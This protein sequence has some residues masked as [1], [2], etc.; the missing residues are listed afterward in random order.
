MATIV[1]Q[2]A[3][4]F[5]GGFLGPVGTAIGSAAG[6]MA[7][8][9]LDRALIESTQHH[10]GARLSGAR[11]FTAEDGAALPRVYGTA[12]IGG[13][14]IWATRFEESRLTERQGFKGGPRV[15]EYSYFANAA[16]A[17]CEGRIAGIRRIWADGRE[18]D[19]EQVEIRVYDGSEGQAA[20][21]LVEARQGEGNTPAY[22][23]TAYVVF[24]RFPIGDYGN[25]IPQFQFEVL[26]PVGS[27]A[28]DIRAVALI[29]GSTEFGLS[30][31][32]VTRSVQAGETEAL[33]RHVL[34]A[35]TDLVASLDE[36]QALCPGLEHVALVATWFGS[37]LRAGECM[38][39]PAVIDNAATGFSDEWKVSGMGRGF[40]P[41]VSTFNGSAAYGGSPSDRTVMDAIAEIKR[42]G[43]KVTL[44]PFV[45]MDIP[46]GNALPD[47]YGG[48]AQ[49][50]YPWRGRIS[51]DPAPLRPGSADKTADARAQV[52]QFCGS[53]VAAD[54]AAHADTIAFNGPLDDWGYRRF[55]LHFA[56]LAAA[57]GG[58]DGFLVGSELRGLTTLRDENNGFPFVEQLCDLA[59]EARA[60]LGPATKITYG[61]DWSEYFGHHPA[62]GSGDVF[63]HLDA[64]WAH[65]AVDAVG[66]D[67]YMPLADWRDAD[68]VEGNPDGFS[69]PYDLDGLKRAMAGGEG[70]DWYYP[71]EAARANR[72]RAPITDGAYGK[73]WVYR[74]KD[75]ESWWSNLHYNRVGGQEAAEPTDW[76]SQ[77]KP[78]WMTEVG[79][80]A[81]DKGPN[82]PNVFPD[83]KS[84]ESAIPYFSNGGRSD[85]ASQRFLAAHFSYWDPAAPGF[86]ASNN[87]LSPVYGGR[88]VDASRIYVWAWDAR[89]FPAFP[90]GQD[91]WKDSENWR[92]G[93]WLNGRLSSLSCGDLID[94]IL[95][96]H[97][98]PQ[99]DTATADGMMHGYVVAD[100]SS[101]RAA[102]E[103][104]IDLYGLSVCEV[105]GKLIF[106]REGAQLPNAVPVT[107]LVVEDRNAVVETV[108]VP[109][110]DLPTEAILGFR[111]PLAE[112]QAASA[113]MVRFGA[114]GLRQETIG[115]PGLLETAEAETLLADWMRRRWSER[116][117]VSFAV[118]APD[119]SIEPGVVV[120]LP[121]AHGGSSFVVTEIEEGV[122][123]RVSA[124][125]IA[126]A[127][128]SASHAG[129]PSAP[130]VPTTLAGRPLALFLDLP[131]TP[132]SSQPHEQF[133][134][135][136][137]N[138]TWRS[139]MVFASPEDTGFMQRSSVG[140]PATVGMLIEAIGP[141]YEGRIDRS[142]A[143]S[144]KLLDGELASVSRLQLLNG[145]NVAAIR[146]G[147]G[148]WELIQFEAAEEYAPSLWRLT[149]L[150]RGQLGTTDAMKAGTPSGAD[151]V[152]IDEAVRPA[153]LLP[154]ELGLS[155]NWRVGPSGYDFSS[156]SFSQYSEAGGVRSRIPFAPVHIRGKRTSAGDFAIT[157]IRRSRIDAD[158][159]LGN[160][161]PL[162]EE[163][164]AYRIEI[165]AVDGGVV[166]MATSAEP[167]LLY[168]ATQISE[169]FDLAP[170][171]IDVSVTQLSAEV[172]WGIPATRRLKLA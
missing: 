12:R 103:P 172:G 71:D 166:R 29:P 102:L 68:Y 52:D 61:A 116:E 111:D 124:R 110:H 152:L 2:A 25:R 105:G 59:G 3:G 160:D 84:I 77:A 153:G 89:P 148:V 48:A 21:P 122:V 46:H 146:S 149:G 75:I 159:W 50:T 108:R 81:V 95:A 69:G 128:P 42:R 138:R 132:G 101:A 123:R 35:A 23:G 96:D 55:L 165:A 53:A 93:H 17:L 28:K 94:A 9:V 151:F 8:Y 38:I 118:A 112:Y 65:P 58:V 13:T 125:Q 121:A 147:I 139:Q 167:A 54:F 5:L 57:A 73:P 86:D 24:E 157:W 164:E 40:A 11:P 130:P 30:P 62:D 85:I 41:T 56:H 20:D 150:L 126:L 15:T 83:P 158:S 169:D 44:Y 135:A 22:R 107:E 14:L 26:R 140:R 114:A 156:S 133:R 60:I 154:A 97:G 64:F 7:G 51:C 91:W 137:W 19:R 170:S 161:V 168:D 33:N 34:H 141:G 10:E 92:L 129:L 113:R 99:A 6:A 79:C 27:L 162:G 90:L 144:V 43:L 163:H 72:T 171:E 74:Y 31:H 66:I 155:L 88:M 109:D 104:V 32:L 87:P 100:P 36:L 18:L 134:V 131:M 127:L 136:V 117:S 120:Q 1:L 82:Q 45:M 63:F 37:D 76:V 142:G 119:A 4:A 47:P 143:M 67:N 16:F 49:A 106:R 78:I 145:A 70:F 115:F 98:L 39:R 80:P